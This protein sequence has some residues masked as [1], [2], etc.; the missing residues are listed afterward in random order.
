M[1]DEQTAED[2]VLAALREKAGRMQALNR[3]LA[4]EETPAEGPAPTSFDGGARR[5]VPIPGDSTA[6]LNALVYGLATGN[7]DDYE[8]RMHLRNPGGWEC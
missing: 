4:G 5:S 2:A 3:L 7:L 8:W 1:S 6:D